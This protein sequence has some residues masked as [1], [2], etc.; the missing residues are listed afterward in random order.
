MDVLKTY[1]SPTRI[2]TPA[3]LKGAAALQLE[4]TSLARLKRFFLLFKCLLLLAALA[5]P[6][7]GYDTST[8]M[9]FARAR[10]ASETDSGFSRAVDY[11][12]L[13]L[14]RWDAVYFASSSARGHLYEQEW[15]FSWVLSKVTSAVARGAYHDL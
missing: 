5:S 4:R 3:G 12:L 10:S 2:S 9:L 13:R 6:G 15:A 14:T 1:R 8:D 7:P 11:A